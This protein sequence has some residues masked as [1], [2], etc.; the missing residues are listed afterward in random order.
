MNLAQIAASFFTQCEAA[1]AYP[2]GQSTTDFVNTVYQ[3]VL[4]RPADA[5]GLSYWVSQLRAGIVAK[6]TFVLALSN[7]TEA[8][9]TRC[10]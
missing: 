3:N 2:A 8:P 4:G 10:T 7:G 9:E 1:I 6:N 5:G